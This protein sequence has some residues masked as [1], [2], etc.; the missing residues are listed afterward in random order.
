MATDPSL[1]T[2][3]AVPANPLVTA[4]NM[5]QGLTNVNSYLA[6]QKAGQIISTS[7]NLE[8]A[9]T[10]LTQDPT[11]APFAGQIVNEYRQGMLAQT[12]RYGE[13][14][15]QA[16]E[17]FG[18]I[19]KGFA[20]SA[21]APETAIPIVSSLLS[22]VSPQNRPMLQTAAGNLLKSLTDGIDLSTPQGQAAYR[23]RSAAIAASS[24]MS[25]EQFAVSAGKPGEVQQ[26]SQIQPTMT[27]LATGAQAP[28]GRP[29]GVGA[30]PSYVSTPG[31]VLPAPA[32]P[33]GGG[34]L[35]QGQPGGGAAPGA[36]PAPFGTL[37]AR[38]PRYGSAV[39]GNP[40][41]GNI[42]GPP[43]TA[44]GNPPYLAGDG[45]PLWS[46][47]TNFTGPV[48]PTGVGGIRVLSP[49]QM[50][51]SKQLSDEWNGPGIRQ[52][53]NAQQAL[54]SLD[55]MDHAYDQMRS[56]GGFLVPGTGAAFRGAFAKA[57]NTMAQITNVTPPFDPQ[58]VSSIEDFNKESNKLG[59]MT[60]SLMLG[61][62]REAAQTIQTMINTV[63]GVNN[64]Y[65]GG[66]LIID[67]LRAQAQRVIDERNFVNEYQARNGGTLLG[68]Q[69]AF[70]REHPAL[71]YANGVL[72]K[73]GLTPT[74][75][76]SRSD[77]QNAIQQGFITRAQG[78]SFLDDLNASGGGQ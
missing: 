61:Q 1:S 49:S 39:G 3:I 47:H 33:P 69:E 14:Q 21:G 74:G 50:D 57:V 20:G 23:Q 41:T 58:T 60:T 48:A 35:G 18:A 73:Y 30:A 54:G 63:P 55:Y 45:R 59:V 78:K 68:G 31:G 15:K 29:F 64:T 44:A 27:S 36:P 4:G 52:F 28:V 43:E 65:L 9:F 67:S 24:G 38:G 5:A 71:Q 10:Q 2:Q 32:I 76:K 13:L 34:S 12:Q 7:P 8:S 22:A 51:Q 56:T 19:E 70:N 16:L 11:V 75:F 6:R 17:G 40:L 37:L 62:Q 66:K 53:D 42:G 26:G 72:D 46:A 77:I 25:P